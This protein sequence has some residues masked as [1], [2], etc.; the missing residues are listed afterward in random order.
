MRREQLRHTALMIAMVMGDYNSAQSQPLVHEEL[1][2]RR[3]L[4]G[5][6]HGSMTAVVDGPDIVILECGDRLHF[7]HACAPMADRPI[8]S[9]ED[10]LA[11]PPGQYMLRW[12]AQ[13]YD[14]T[15][16]D[17]FGYHAVHRCIRTATRMPALPRIGTGAVT[18]RS[19]VRAAAARGRNYNTR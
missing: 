19:R 14:R 15:V 8:V 6:D 16:T 10:W 13:Q 5:I 1:L 18:R 11:S 17:I 9:W 2:H 7:Q 3:R 4:A 12:E